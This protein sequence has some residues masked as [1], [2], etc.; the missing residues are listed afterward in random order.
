MEPLR[1]S[2]ALSDQV[3]ESVRG[4]ITSGAWAPGEI[5]SVSEVAQLVGVSR[6]PA[7][8]ALLKLADAGLIRFE[9]NVGFRVQGSSPRTLAEIFHMRILLEGPAVRL[10]ATSPSDATIKQ[11]EEATERMRD[12]A[13][14]ADEP[15]FMLH[16]CE[17]HEVAIGGSGNV[18]L[19]AVVRGL[20]DATMSLGASTV[21]HSRQLS[22]ILDEHAPILAAI[23]A[24][25]P[26]SAEAA[27]VRHLSHTG[28]LLLDRL[29]HDESLANIPFV[30]ETWPR[31]AD[32]SEQ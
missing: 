26:D 2:S 22:D 3:L 32:G 29:G 18:R 30:A 13:V 25:Q 24:K 31:T 21:K 5:H 15:R 1:R 6:T 12:A 20:R 23:K 19:V 16:D 9:P 7:R 28:A 8:E 4:A 27:L 10:T 14:S 11:L 17:F